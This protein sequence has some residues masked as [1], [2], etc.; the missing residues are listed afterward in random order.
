MEIVRVIATILFFA[1]FSVMAVA[2]IGSL[3]KVYL[4]KP[5]DKKEEN[6][7]C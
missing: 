4:S 3:I 7:T 2:P 5:S 1:G 6:T